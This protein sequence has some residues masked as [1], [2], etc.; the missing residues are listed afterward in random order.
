MAF[1]ALPAAEAIRRL[2][3]PHA[4]YLMR[5][6]PA[7]SRTAASAFPAEVWVLGRG[8]PSL[9]GGGQGEARQESRTALR[10]GSPRAARAAALG[11]AALELRLGAIVHFG[12][13]EAI[14]R[15]SPSWP[16]SPRI[17]DPT[18]RGAAV[19]ALEL[20]VNH[21]EMGPR[22]VEVLGQLLDQHPRVRE[23]LTHVMQND[24]SAAM[25]HLAADA[26]RVPGGATSD[27]A[28]A[29]PAF[30]IPRRP[31]PRPWER[32][33][34]R[35]AAGHCARWL[36][37]QS[38]GADRLGAG[39][40]ENDPAIRGAAVNALELLVNHP[41]MGPRAVEVLGRLLKPASS[42]AGGIDPCDAECCTSGSAATGC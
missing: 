13:Q 38:G 28:V 32:R 35:G 21:P 1:E 42:G 6:P 10:S 18:I 40:Q 33:S 17:S 4:N 30:P 14:R 3:G 5:F 37:G 19:D 24:A 20:L 27:T 15:R 41:E 12:R 11:S 16:R 34:R 25:Q 22:A 7:E 2:F 39:R 31:A 29:T 26:L 8:L 36:A 9:P 23:V